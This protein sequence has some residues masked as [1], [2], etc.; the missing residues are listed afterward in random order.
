MTLRTM[1]RLNE[2]FEQRWPMSELE[3]SKP[4]RVAV[5]PRVREIRR[6]A[7]AARR[8]IAKLEAVTETP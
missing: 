2:E 6:K 8:R 5:L 1:R 3:P 7:A 4:K